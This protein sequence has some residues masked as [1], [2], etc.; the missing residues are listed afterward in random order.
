MLYIAYY[1]SNHDWFSD[2]TGA[3]TRT[4]LSVAARADDVCQA[5]IVICPDLEELLFGIR[6]LHYTAPFGREYVIK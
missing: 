5:K 6:K 2:M 1:N 3:C 4:A